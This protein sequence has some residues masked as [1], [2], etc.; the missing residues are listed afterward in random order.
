MKS[1]CWKT[2]QCYSTSSLLPGS[3]PLEKKTTTQ[4]S[5]SAQVP[6]ARFNTACPVDELRD[7]RF[8]REASLEA[9]G[10]QNSGRGARGNG[11]G[12][13]GGNNAGAAK[14]PLQHVPKFKYFAKNVF[15]PY[16]SEDGCPFYL[17]DADDEKS[18]F[19]KGFIAENV[20]SPDTCEA[21]WRL[22]MAVALYSSAVQVGGTALL[23]NLD[24]RGRAGDKT[25]LKQLGELLRSPDGQAF[26]KAAKTLNVGIG[27]RVARA[28]ARQAVKTYVSFLTKKEPQLRK[29]VS[30]AA[31]FTAKIYQT[32]MCIAE[33]MDLLACP[34]T[35]AAAMQGGKNQPAL[36]QKW[37]RD[38]KDK[39]K[40]IDAL[41]DSFVKKM[42]TSKK[43]P[44]AKRAAADSSDDEGDE[45]SAESASDQ[46]ELSDDAPDEGSDS[47]EADDDKESESGDD[48]KPR[49]K[50][51][52]AA[53]PARRDAKGSGRANLKKK[54]E[55]SD[56]S[57][58]LDE[59][60][61]KRT[62]RSSRDTKGRTS[63]RRASTGE[64]MK[65]KTS[66]R[67]TK[68]ARRDA[69]DESAGSDAEM[70]AGTKAADTA[71]RRGRA[72]TPEKNPEMTL[73]I[74]QM[75]VALTEWRVSDMQEASAA[76]DTA[77][78]NAVALADASRQDAFDGIHRNLE[79]HPPS[80]SYRFDRICLVRDR[81]IA[82]GTQSRNDRAR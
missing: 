67:R 72:E 43:P 31:S 52:P 37:I 9:M 50:K 57:E 68:V 55:E 24:D 2:A 21:L 13:K 58:E 80:R 44:G 28:E 81:R 78:N 30:R 61:P 8:F 73:N 76:V 3:K 64:T 45:E 63:G 25:G 6:A 47:N 49:P 75:Q 79:S 65:A 60:A 26:L 54:R 33:H 38:P 39:D 77:L 29:A 53:V 16:P 22:G 42:E 11:S 17:G 19:K 70:D 40:L 35:W 23:D 82:A 62:R 34:K 46:D 56:A 15:A 74:A 32:T 41:T 10:R 18:F 4:Y 48:S 36:T 5:C 51:N 69:D 7:T 1:L 27:G 14:D 12:R 66:S 71:S 59:P 20:V